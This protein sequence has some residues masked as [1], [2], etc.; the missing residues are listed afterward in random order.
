MFL[1]KPFI[2]LPECFEL[3][4]YLRV[5]TEFSV[6]RLITIELNTE[7]IPSIFHSYRLNV[8][9]IVFYYE[10]NQHKLVFIWSVMF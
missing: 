3:K 6:S 4:H 2:E 8:V 10:F 5:V 7:S 1:F 9:L